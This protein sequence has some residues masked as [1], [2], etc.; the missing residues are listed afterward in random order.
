MR[1]SSQ[2]NDK[3]PMAGDLKNPTPILRN[4]GGRFS[5]SDSRLIVYPA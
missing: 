2:E 4:E 3:S 1:K 5:P